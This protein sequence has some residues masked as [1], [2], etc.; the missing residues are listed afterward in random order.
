MSVQDKIVDV[1]ELEW[2]G[3]EGD[4]ERFESERKQLGKAAG[5]QKLGASLYRVPPGKTAWPR[6]AHLANEEALF[7]LSGEGELRIGS[8]TVSVHAGHYV[9]LPP[10][11]EHAHQLVNTSDEPIEYLCVSTMEEPDVIKYPD[12]DKIGVFVGAAPGG[13]SD[14]RTY[15]GVHRIADAVDYWEGEE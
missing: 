15:D 1:A 4:G 10:G 3:H 6:H 14:A 9:A 8:E 12:S 7:I 13:D 5:A 11:E 2:S